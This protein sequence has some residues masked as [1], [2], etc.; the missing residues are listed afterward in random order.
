MEMVTGDTNEI[1]L[2][3][4][5]Q[6]GKTE[7]LLNIIG[8]FIDAQPAPQLVVYPTLDTSRKFSRAKLALMLSET[9]CLA[10][11]VKDPRTRDSGNTILSKDYSGGSLVIAGSNSP[12]SLRQISVRVVIQDEID[13]YEIS[14]GVEGDAC[15]LADARASNFHDAVLVKSSSPTVKGASRIEAAYEKS[16]QRK[17]YV[18]CPECGE[19][20][21]L[22][23]ANV[24]W[25]KDQPEKA[26]YVCPHCKAELS[27]Q[28]R[29]TMVK[30][31]EWRAENP[32][33]KSRGYSL[34]GLYRIMGRKKQFDSYLHEFAHNFLEAKHRGR[35]ALMVWTNTFLNETWQESGERIESED[36]MKRCEE[37]P[38]NSVPEGVLC[39]TAGA[40][41]Q[42]DRL[43]ITVIGWGVAEES[44]G[45]EHRT[46]H[47]DPE[48]LE[49]WQDLDDFINRKWRHP[50]GVNMR[51]NCVCVDSGYSTRNVYSFTKPRQ[52]RR[53][54]SVKGSSRSGA[55]LVTKR[56]VKMGR[57]T[58]WLVGGETAKDS[59][60]ARLR[61][62]EVGPRYIHFPHGHGF[63]EEYFRQLTAEEVRTRMQ[64]GF[65]IRY[66]KKIRER[67]EALD[68]FQYNLAAL[69]I[70]NPN[71]ERLVENLSKP[72]PEP[73]DDSPL[74][75][76]VK[77][78]KPM[79]KQSGGGFVDAW[80]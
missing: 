30:N 62:E 40:D 19:H 59:I 67:N 18:P 29:V 31:G 71:F 37:Y 38:E 79:P 73:V 26:V 21:V 50:S 45:I 23:W 32:G 55:P 60:F 66:Y 64:H 12:S 8:Y 17:W 68:C 46:I 36:M 74:P 13:T 75:A 24:Q 3:W 14:A 48:K 5:A 77:E 56:V 41:V 54:Y 57:T 10:D 11:K 47:G 58:L 49:V 2:Q 44:W 34:S 72:E 15:F 16:D 76:T 51:I 53:V 70:L 1:V 42:K 4:G 22:Q 39:L 20:Q 27:D 7:I 28:Q 78:S 9:P 35:S 6:L 65:P 52:P 25:P 80:R 63:D 61:I 33:A 69:E 43:E